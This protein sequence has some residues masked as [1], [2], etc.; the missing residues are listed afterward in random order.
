MKLSTKEDTTSNQ[1]SLSEVMTTSE[2]EKR[3][4]LPI[5]S[6]RVA[7]KRGRFQN[8][9]QQGLVRRSGNVWLITEKAMKEVF[10]D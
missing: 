9:I 8:Q 5:G 7:I 2:A 4:Q 3:R 10:G 6:I 1:F